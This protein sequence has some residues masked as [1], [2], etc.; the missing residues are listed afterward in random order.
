[1]NNFEISFGFYPGVLFG[2]RT[3]REELR[4]NHVLYIPFADVCMTVYHD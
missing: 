4:T 1:M 2:F 3:Y